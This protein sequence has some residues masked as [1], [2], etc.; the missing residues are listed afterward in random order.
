MDLSLKEVCRPFLKRYSV[1][2][3]H[4]TLDILRDEGLIKFKRTTQRNFGFQIIDESVI[5]KDVRCQN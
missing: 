3:V 2:S 1:S 4:S 5:E